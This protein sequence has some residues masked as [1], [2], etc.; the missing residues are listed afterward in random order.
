[1]LSIKE[2]QTGRSYEITKGSDPDKKVVLDFINASTPGILT[3]EALLL[4]LIM[5]LRSLNVELPCSENHHVI[6]LLVQATEVLA[7][8]SRR[9]GQKEMVP[10]AIA[11]VSTTPAMGA[12]V[13]SSVSKKTTGVIA[14]E[15]AGDKLQRAQ[16][17]GIPVLNEND[18]DELLL[19]QR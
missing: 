6:D 5:R 4:V 19:K 13:S 18:L 1:M 2:T 7:L 12:K 17:L 10:I 14:G 11:E 8:R 3:N 15:G 9:L 16:E